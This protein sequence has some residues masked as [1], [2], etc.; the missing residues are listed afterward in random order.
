MGNK[1]LNFTT[2][3]INII[4]NALACRPYG[5]VYEVINNIMEQCRKNI[6]T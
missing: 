3:E 2:D 6:D 1:K 5:E 4:L